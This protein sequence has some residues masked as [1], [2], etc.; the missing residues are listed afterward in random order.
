VHARASISCYDILVQ[1]LGDDEYRRLLELRTGLRRFLH[2][3]EQ[4]A[5]AVGLT[6]RQHQLLLAVRGHG[7]PPGPTVGE[8]AGDLLL[9]HH[10]AVEL[11]NRAEAAGL[12]RRVS[13]PQDHRV[14]RLL[15]TPAGAQRLAE[16]SAVHLEELSRLRES[17]MPIWEGL[18]PAPS[19]R[20][21][22]Q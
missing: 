16:L 22:I 2:W 13:D 15:L 8:V 7:G 14:V 5:R 1:P 17:L 21:R 12:L 18:E 3:S 10:S 9:R 6:G 20:G 4:R 11:V 19:P